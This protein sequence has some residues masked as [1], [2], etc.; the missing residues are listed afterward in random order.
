MPGPGEGGHV[1][2]EEGEILTGDFSGSQDG[3]GT[4][5]AGAHQEYDGGGK[6]DRVAKQSED[7]HQQ[8]DQREIQIPAEILP[9]R[10][11]LPGEDA[12]SITALF[13]RLRDCE[14]GDNPIKSAWRTDRILRLRD[15]SNV[16]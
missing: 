4:L 1:R 8:V 2:R 5:G 15:I 9:Q 7:N 13:N 6:E 11:V 12:D 16:N 3:E 14:T 10:S